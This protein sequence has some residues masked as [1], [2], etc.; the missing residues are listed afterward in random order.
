MVARKPSQSPKLTARAPG[1]AGGTAVRQQAAGTGGARRGGGPGAR[2]TAGSGR[3]DTAPSL[4][5]Q[6]PLPAGASPPPAAFFAAAFLAG[7]FFAAAFLAGAFFAGAFLAG[8]F[9]AGPR[10]RRSASS[11]LARSSV[12]ALEL[13]AL[14]QARVGLAV[15]DVRAEAA[16]LDDH[17]LAR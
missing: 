7:A 4:R 9:G 15:G 11:S 10:A 16:L 14:A 12:S 13:V 2:G 3:R 6:R 17:R 5:R 8:F 1:R